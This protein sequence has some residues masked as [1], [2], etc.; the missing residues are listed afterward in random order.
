LGE[1]HSKRG[2]N[3]SLLGI[4]PV[5]HVQ[6]VLEKSHDLEKGHGVV[7]IAH[8]LASVPTL[9]PREDFHLDDVLGL[10]PRDLGFLEF[11]KEPPMGHELGLAF[12]VL[13]RTTVG[14]VKSITTRSSIISMG[15]MTLMSGLITCC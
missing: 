8:P 15:V 12:G 7:E 6:V 9:L 4:V 3:G 10:G 14:N 2:L 5:R 13:V 11:A 1:K